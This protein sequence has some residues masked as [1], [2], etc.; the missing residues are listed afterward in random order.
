MHKGSIVTIYGDTLTIPKPIFGIDSKNEPLTL[1]GF[2]IEKPS[3][4]KKEEEVEKIP[5]DFDPYSINNVVAM[6]G[7]MSYFP[8]MNLGKTMKE[9]VVQVSTI[10]IATPPS[11]LGYKPTND[12]LLEIEV[13]RMA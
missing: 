1:D 3:C 5:M 4:E 7:K 9:A 2:E 12:D 11:V 13:R 6:M 10:P 8:R